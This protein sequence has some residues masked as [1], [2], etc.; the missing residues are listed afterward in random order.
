MEKESNIGLGAE[1][2]ELGFSFFG[3]QNLLDSIMTSAIVR[4]FAWLV[5]VLLAIVFGVMFIIGS[6]D[7]LKSKKAAGSAVTIENQIEG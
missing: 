1:S 6:A 2:L 3:L 5:C 4:V 7:L